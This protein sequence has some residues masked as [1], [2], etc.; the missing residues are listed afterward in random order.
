M[1]TTTVQSLSS[2]IAPLTTITHSARRVGRCGRKLR[3]YRR[4]A[5]MTSTELTGAVE[6]LV[7]AGRV[8]RVYEL[9]RIYTA[10]LDEGTVVWTARKSRR[11]RASMVVE[12]SL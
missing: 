9:N 8:V 3:A 5:S 12:V 2:I 6:Q 4:E 10:T 1:R 11:H 7:R